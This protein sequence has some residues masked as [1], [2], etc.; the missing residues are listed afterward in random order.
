MP[1]VEPVAIVRFGLPKAHVLAISPTGS[2]E[3]QTV[4]LAVWPAQ[5]CMRLK[6]NRTHVLVR[7]VN[8]IAF[9]L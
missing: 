9:T 7:F 2:Q 3:T 4:Y 8:Q 1:A 5:L 6:T